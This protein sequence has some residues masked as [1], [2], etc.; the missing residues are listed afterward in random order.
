M[1][2]VLLV[3]DDDVDA[4]LIG[5]HAAAMAEPKLVLTRVVSAEAGRQLLAECTFDIC[6]LDFWLGC[7]TSLRLLA[8]LDVAP[9]QL[10]AVVLTSLSTPDIGDLCRLAGARRFIGKERLDAVSLRNAI[11]QALAERATGRRSCSAGHLASLRDLL[12]TSVLGRLSQAQ[13]YE[14]F[15]RRAQARD[16]LAGLANMSETARFALFEWLVASQPEQGGHALPFASL[17]TVIAHAFEIAAATLTSRGQTLVTSDI[18]GLPAAIS[19]PVPLLFLVHEFVCRASA[20][21]AGDSLIEVSMIDE[22]EGVCI[23]LDGRLAGQPDPVGYGP[24]FEEL[25]A[26]LDGSMSAVTSCRQG[27]GFA[28]QLR[29]PRRAP[30]NLQ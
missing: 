15:E 30:A 2:R 5:F 4:K 12:E 26:D 8:D 18:D 11:L 24:L 17:E 21:S 20:Q 1:V 3:E 16:R 22:A 9:L 7:E 19:H 6:I 14:A 10:P 28:V 13:A 27:P 29:L 23:Q 25:L